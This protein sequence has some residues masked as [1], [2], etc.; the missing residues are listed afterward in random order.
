MCFIDIC[1]FVGMQG[2]DLHFA[3]VRRVRENI[4]QVSFK[5]LAEIEEIDARLLKESILELSED[6]PYVLILNGDKKRIDFSREAKEFL[7][8]DEKLNQNIICEAYVAKS[9]SN[10]LIFHFF[11]NFYKPNFPV[12][13]FDELSEA[14]KWVE[15]QRVIN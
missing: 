8:Q 1:Y 9:M 3:D 6:H 4:I 12:Q 15:S 11:I 2:I 10:K 7:T 14:Y 13:V 5:D